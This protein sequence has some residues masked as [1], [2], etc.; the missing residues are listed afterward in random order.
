MF[1]SFFENVPDAIFIEDNYGT[2]LNV[3]K[4]ACELQGISKKQLI[5]KNISELIPDAD[6]S[7]LMA[8]FKK[9]FNGEITEHISTYYKITGEP[10]D[11]EIK[12][13]RIS[14]KD[15][16]AVLLNVREV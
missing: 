2:I 10:A 4:K 7:K 13:M 14:Y 15:V 5:G 6:K 9:L 16:P 1:N 11:I 12:A 3:N 8:D